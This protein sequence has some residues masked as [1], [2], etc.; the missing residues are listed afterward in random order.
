MSS[1]ARLRRL[2]ARGD[3]SNTARCLEH[4]GLRIEALLHA[5]ETGDESVLLALEGGGAN[6]E[7]CGQLT[8]YGVLARDSAADDDPE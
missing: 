4:G 2:E 6:C 8:L 1:E 7:L 5:S 3:G